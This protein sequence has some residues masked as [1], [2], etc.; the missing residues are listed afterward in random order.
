MSLTAKICQSPVVGKVTNV[1]KEY[2]FS[3]AVKNSY[4]GRIKRQVTLRMDEHTISY[5]K[6][7]ERHWRQA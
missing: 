4:A 7:L 3:K 2:D 1:R 5:I 6:Q